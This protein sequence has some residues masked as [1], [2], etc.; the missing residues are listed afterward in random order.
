MKKLVCFLLFLFLVSSC[1]SSDEI[2][3]PIKELDKVE[4][5][6]VKKTVSVVESNPESD[7]EKISILNFS[8]IGDI[9][10]HDVN[11]KYRPLSN[12]YKNVKDVLLADDLSFGNLE[13]PVDPEKVYSTYPNFNVKPEYVQAAIDGGLDIFSMANN[14][15]TDQG[16]QSI[17]NTHKEMEKLEGISF[18][19]IDESPLIQM[20]PETISIDGW[21]IGFLAVTAILNS[22]EGSEYVNLVS[23]KN[24]VKRKGFIKYIRK[25]VDKYD[26]FIL[27][28]H[29]G[30][31]Y[32]TSPDKDKLSFYRELVKAGVGIVWGHHPHVLQPMEI[33][34]VDDR[35]GLILPSC[36]NFI[37][38]QTWHLNPEDYDE[39]RAF[40]GDSAIFQVQLIKNGDIAE[41]LN[42]V[43]LII[44][45][46]RDPKNGMGVHYLED[47]AVSRSI[48]DKWRK[49]Y[50]SRLP[51]IEELAGMY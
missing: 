20:V 38:G 41:V 8:F 23:Y 34:V 49:Y 16:I 3:N 35:R 29:A 18:S 27:S 51:L 44:S 1:V 36:G 11:Y 21:N 4:D 5:I 12:I 14:H 10:A 9:M 7:M 15:T 6:P 46:Y 24:P 31:E 13:F 2:V 25:T 26:F 50:N 43:P 39:S 40:T 19:G 37:S 48:P 45:N 17:V 22:Y 30:R 33:V 28:I 42:V 47:L 32:A